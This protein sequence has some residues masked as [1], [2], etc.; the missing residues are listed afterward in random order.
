MLSTSHTS[1]WALPHV[2]CLT[3]AIILGVDPDLPRYK[4][5]G[6]PESDSGAH[7]DCAGNEFPRTRIGSF[8]FPQDLR[9]PGCCSH[10]LRHWL[11]QLHPHSHCWSLWFACPSPVRLLSA[12]MVLCNTHPQQGQ[13]A[14]RTA[15]LISP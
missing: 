15:N 8:N 5:Q 12:S 14:G 2:T 9:F 7:Y 3:S 13:G 11:Q 1:P 4:G 10:I 6:G